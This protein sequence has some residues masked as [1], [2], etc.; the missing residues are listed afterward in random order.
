MAGDGRG[1]ETVRSTRTILLDH[2]HPPFP[3]SV[4]HA[5]VW[6]KWGGGEVGCT[7][8]YVY[9]MRR[10]QNYITHVSHSPHPL[11]HWR[12]RESQRVLSHRHTQGE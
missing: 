2:P 4:G 10:E 6:G 11:G 7:S 5:C 1:R 8:E 3:L 12:W 9:L